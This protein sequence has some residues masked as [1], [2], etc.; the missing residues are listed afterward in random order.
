MTDDAKTND[1]DSLERLSVHE[2]ATVVNF[3]EQLLAAEQQWLM[4][5][6]S[7]L[8]LSQSF[9]IAAYVQMVIADAHECGSP[10]RRFVALRLLLPLLGITFCVVVGLSVRAAQ[11]IREALNEERARLSDWLNAAYGTRIPVLWVKPRSHDGALARMIW[12]GLLP[13]QLPW[14]VAA[15]WVVVLIDFLLAAECWA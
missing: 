4:S 8:F 5:R 3:V 7:W 11:T 9:C 14:A 12:L 6:L 2:I 13:V 15:F 10:A 1:H